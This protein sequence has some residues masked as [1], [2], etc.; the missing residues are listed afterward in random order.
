MRSEES[1]A[2]PVRGDRDPSKLL[3]LHINSRLQALRYQGWT[4]TKISKAFV[5][6]IPAVKTCPGR[7]RL[8]ESVCY[9]DRGRYVFPSVRESLQK[10]WEL[11][12]RKDFVAI[13]N[14]DFA[15]IR[16]L[17]WLPPGKKYTCACRIHGS[18]DFYDAAYARKWLAI[19]RENP[20]VYFFGYTR[21]WRIPS[22]RPYLRALAKLPNC[23]LYL[24]CDRET[25]L[26]SRKFHLD[27]LPI[28][29]MAMDDTD[30]PPRPV[31]VVFRV[32][33]KT[34]QKKMNQSVVCPAENGTGVDFHCLQCRF[35]FRDGPASL[36]PD[37]LPGT[38]QRFALPL[39]L[40]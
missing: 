3:T 27:G 37:E 21:S 19:V 17:F 24:S 4:D 12:R 13:V 2:D 7:S 10:R 28:A 16:K 23:R 6:S 26:P 34:V 15:E 32:Q 22:I 39:L 1:K 40:S 11:S 38:R 36:P 18:G 29:W 9:A 14:Q 30:A 33:R 5:F 31:K 35:C 8:C 25:G 20:D